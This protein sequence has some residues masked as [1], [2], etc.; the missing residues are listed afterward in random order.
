MDVLNALRKDILLSFSAHHVATIQ[1]FNADKQ[2][3][4]ASINYRK[5]YFEKN[6]QTGVYGPVLVDYPLLVDCPVICLGGGPGA[7]TFPIQAGDECLVLFNDRDMDN[8]LKGGAGTASATSRLH[9]FADG[10]VLVGVRSLGKVLTGYDMVRAVLANGTTLIGVG[11]S[12]I[13]IANQTT[14]LN[15]LLQTLLTQ[16]QTLVTATAAITVTGVAAG[17]AASGPP[18]NAAAIVAIGAQL[19]TTAT[20]IGGLLE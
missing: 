4:S 1:S 14:T 6:A 19:A 3:A 11:P 18:A 20:Q 13:K 12:L 8:W 5:T 2:T 16:L 10:I 9:S 17:S 7:L 15:T